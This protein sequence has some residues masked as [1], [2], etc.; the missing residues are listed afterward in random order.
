MPSLTSQP[1][2]HEQLVLLQSIGP[3]PPEPER[4]R[5]WLTKTKTKTRNKP[6]KPQRNTTGAA[7]PAAPVPNINTGFKSSAR[8]HLPKTHAS[9]DAVLAP[10]QKETS[11]HKLMHR[12]RS[13]RGEKKKAALRSCRGRSAATRVLVSPCTTGYG[14]PGGYDA[15][16]QV[17]FGVRVLRNRSSKSHRREIKWRRHCSRVSRFLWSIGGYFGVDLSKEDEKL[18]VCLADA[19]G[20]HDSRVWGKDF[21]ADCRRRSSHP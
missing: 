1:R 6:G 3:S 14:R 12:Q 16:R 17:W 20:F 9:R 15:V 19:T 21:R 11:C 13:T 5:R 10:L 8:K 7:F 4:R 2:Q 18:R